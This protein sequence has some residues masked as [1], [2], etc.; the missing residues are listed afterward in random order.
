VVAL[1]MVLSAEH[2]RA[3]A[4]HARAEKLAADHARLL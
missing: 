3:D 2:A 1:E 4:E